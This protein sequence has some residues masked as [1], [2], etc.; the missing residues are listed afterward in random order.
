MARGRSFAV[1]VLNARRK[2]RLIDNKSR[3]EPGCVVRLGI[4]YVID[5]ISLTA[6]QAS[7]FDLNK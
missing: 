1:T 3:N 2:K 7:C 4:T 6:T 5:L